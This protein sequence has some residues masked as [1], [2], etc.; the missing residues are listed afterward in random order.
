M[1]NNEKFNTMSIDEK[2][3]FFY[4]LEEYTCRYCAYHYE[5]NG[6]FKHKQECRKG[7]KKWLESEVNIYETNKNEPNKNNT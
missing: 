2:V 3:E 5:K 4:S 7:I 6:C 1:T